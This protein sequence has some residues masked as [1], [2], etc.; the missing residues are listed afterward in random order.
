MYYL[1]NKSIV[2]TIPQ[3][4][5]RARLDRNTIATASIWTDFVSLL[6]SLPPLPQTVSTRR[7]RY[8]FKR[9]NDSSDAELYELSTTNKLSAQ[10][11][12]Y[13]LLRR[14]ETLHRLIDSDNHLLFWMLAVQ[15]VLW[16]DAVRTVCAV[17]VNFVRVCLNDF[18]ADSFC[19][20][21]SRQAQYEFVDSRLRF[22]ERDY[23]VREVNMHVCI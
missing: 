9:W 4:L 22:V 21:A 15:F 23:L 3:S 7:D 19:D 2:S 10:D 16:C 6:L 8:V 13:V 14:L 12:I 11:T 1:Q 20:W 5:I 17:C 18:S